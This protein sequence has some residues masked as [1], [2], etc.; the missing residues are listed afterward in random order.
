MKN[1]NFGNQKYRYSKLLIYQTTK[2]KR[3]KNTEK[4]TKNMLICTFMVAN[5]S[6]MQLSNMYQ[7]VEVFSLFP[8]QETSG[9]I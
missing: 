1:F 3:F 9:E 7:N 8:L 2:D 4:W 6:E 5:L